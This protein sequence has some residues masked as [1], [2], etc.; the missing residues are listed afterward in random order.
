MEYVFNAQTNI[1]LPRDLAFSTIDLQ[2][3]YF[4]Y[5]YTNNI[6]NCKLF[7]KNPYS[8]YF[9]QLYPSTINEYQ[10]T[11]D[12]LNVLKSYTDS[13]S[14]EC[15][16][17]TN[18]N[19]LSTNLE[20]IDWICV[21]KLRSLICGL[22]QSNIKHINAVKPDGLWWAQPS[23]ELFW[24]FRKIHLFFMSFAQKCSFDRPST[25]YDRLLH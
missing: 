12:I 2:K 13:Q 6:L 10:L 25:V 19:L 9:K 4:Y 8:S 16:M 14:N 18:F 23:L 1:Y 21:N 11:D 17:K 3:H 15:Y 22:A 7:K 5:N 24:L 20:H